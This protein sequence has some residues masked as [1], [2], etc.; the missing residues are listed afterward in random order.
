MK[1]YSL[2]GSPNTRKVLAVSHH[3]DLNLEIEQLDFLRG[4]TRKPEFLAINQNG[5][6]PVLEDGS[7]VLWESNA[8]MQYLV[9]KVGGSPIFPTD[10]K[11]RTEV[12]RWQFWEL[13]HFNKAFGTLVFE[14]VIKPQF[15]M[16]NA[17]EDLVSFCLTELA[18]FA[19]V[20]EHHLDS[21]QYL[22]GD[23]LTIADYS[24]VCL[25][26]YRGATAFDWSPFPQINRYLDRIR[27]SD[28]W[29]KADPAAQPHA[30][31]A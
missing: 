28:A 19:P 2:P 26:K 1:L 30:V 18:R 15:G 4:D 16:G 8:I 7:F 23:G 11:L 24:M 13:T 20:L 9:E 21:R 22:V 5:M 6:V 17:A 3:L 27:Q 29:V 31:A 25:E 10:L 12:L 14:S